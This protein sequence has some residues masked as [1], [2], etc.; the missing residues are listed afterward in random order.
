MYNETLFIVQ[1]NSILLPSQATVLSPMKYLAPP[2][3]EN[4]FSE[5][6]TLE[7]RICSYRSK[8]LS[9]MLVS[10]EKRGKMKMAGL[11]L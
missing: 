6:P 3:Q 8:L 9:Y 2:C 1:T 10:V 11:L 7:E 4:G 5:G